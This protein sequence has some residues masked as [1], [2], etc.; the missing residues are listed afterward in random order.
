[1]PINQEGLEKLAWEIRSLEDHQET[2]EGELII[3]ARRALELALGRSGISLD[4]SG[5]DGIGVLGPRHLVKASPDLM[6]TK[7]AKKVVEGGMWDA[8]Q[9][10]AWLLELLEAGD[11]YIS[12]EATAAIVVKKTDGPLL[13]AEAGRIIVCD[14]LADGY[15]FGVGGHLHP[16]TYTNPAVQRTLDSFIDAIG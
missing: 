13:E 1:M 3:A 8:S 6:L 9:S 2:Y 4:E 7:R 5:H 14:V 10:N 11:D 12:K 15:L 16:D